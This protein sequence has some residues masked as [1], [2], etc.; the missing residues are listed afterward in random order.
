MAELKRERDRLSRAIAALEGESPKA[1]AKRSAVPNRAARS[2]KKG[3]PSHLGR[4]ETAVGPHE[5]TMGGEKTEGF[6]GA[7]IKPEGCSEHFAGV[8]PLCQNQAKK[9]C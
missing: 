1:T 4:Q 5:E 8:N 6:Q 9:N 3:R 2:K 7:S